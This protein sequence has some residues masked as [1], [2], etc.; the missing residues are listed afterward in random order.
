MLLMTAECKHL[1]FSPLDVVKQSVWTLKILRPACDRLQ[2]RPF[3]SPD[4]ISERV[5]SVL[6]ILLAAG[7][8]TSFVGYR[9]FNFLYR[10]SQGGTAFAVEWLLRRED[11]DI[12]VRHLNLGNT[13]I[14]DLISCSAGVENENL[15][16]L[17]ITNGVDIN[18][19][20]SDELSS[21]EG[22]TAIHFAVIE[23][24]NHKASR[25][26][27]LNILLRNGA[28]PHAVDSYGLTPTAIAM[29]T[30]Q[31]FFRW[32]KSLEE[33]DQLSEE[34]AMEDVSRSSYLQ[35]AGW[36][37]HS[38]FKLFTCKFHAINDPRIQR[39]ISF[40]Y[41][42][43]SMLWEPWWYDLLRYIR[44]ERGPIPPLPRGWQKYTS[45]AGH[46]S[47]FSEELGIQTLRRPRGKFFSN[48]RNPK[49]RKAYAKGS[50]EI[51]TRLPR[52]HT[53]QRSGVKRRRYLTFLKKLHAHLDHL[54]HHPVFYP[55]DISSDSEADYSDE[56]NRLS[57]EDDLSYE[58]DERTD[59]LDDESDIELEWSDE[60]DDFASWQEDD[61]ASGEQ[62][63]ASDEEVL[64]EDA[65]EA[66]QEVHINP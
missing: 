4:A 66:L 49:A 27:Y 43:K 32:R 54:K 35:T 9:G 14:M 8:N 34:F 26:A 55:Q 38:L 51:K 10:C 15:L 39:S 30:S 18:S 7:A 57:S 17:L 29:R 60:E 53:N 64:Y 6:R 50:A 61:L 42:N 63:V 20:S 12:D 11:S 33:L 36:D 58:E 13:S 40:C 59:Q 23:L 56:D 5:I 16:N 21:T 24:R 28:D 44:L 65:L 46:T 25:A 47:Y 22:F 31:S 48:M 62:A 37:G 45:K 41:G 3:Y 52:L 19:Q 1:T 2:Y